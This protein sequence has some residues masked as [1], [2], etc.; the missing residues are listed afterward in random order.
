MNYRLRQKGKIFSH[1]AGLLRSTLCMRG[2][3]TMVVT[4]QKILTAQ[5]NLFRITQPHANL[6]DYAEFLV[7]Y[8]LI[9][10]Q[11]NINKPHKHE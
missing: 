3:E 1:T 11:N 5:S 7:G 9:F 8:I 2:I 10:E 4:L 6:D